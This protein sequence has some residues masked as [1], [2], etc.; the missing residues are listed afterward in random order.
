MTKLKI[1]NEKD[2]KENE[3][4]N[5]EDGEAHQGEY[6]PEESKE[7]QGDEAQDESTGGARES[8]ETDEPETQE[9]PAKRSKKGKKKKKTQITFEQYEAISGAIS[10]YLRSKE[11]ATDDSE[12]GTK[13]KYL[14]RG[15]V[16]DWYLEQIESQ[17]G[18]SMDEYHRMK[19][20]VDVVIRRLIT[21]EHT[22]IYIGGDGAVE[23]LPEK[24]RKIHQNYEAA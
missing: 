21:V 13:S 4:E 6:K 8:T 10:T 5:D 12:D 1:D 18:D 2:V 16:A 7:P 14:T 11:G 17:L 9:P 19:K 3:E 20:L 24:D 15:E 22:L 23:G